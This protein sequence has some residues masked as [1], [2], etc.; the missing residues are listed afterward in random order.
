MKMESNLI[1]DLVNKLGERKCI[2]DSALNSRYVHI[3]KMHEPLMAKCVLLPESTTDVSE[4]MK[5][6]YKYDQKI[7]VHGGLTNLVGSTETNIDDVVISMEKLNDIEEIDVSSRTITAQAGVVLE[8]II[9]TANDNDLLFP[10]NFGAKGS[11]Q[12]GGVISTNAGGL[13]VF[14]YG[15]TR[16]LVLG[17]EVVMANGSIISSM[18]KI[19][20]DNS[21]YDLKQMFIGSEGTLG[22]ITKA[23]LRL[24][25]KPKSRVS[26]LVGLNDYDSVI[27]LLKYMD[28]SLA[29]NLS[30]FE[31]I[32]GKTYELMTSP[33]AINKPPIL[34]GFK[35]YVL[36]EA[37]G[38]HQVNDKVFFESVLAE[39]LDKELFV[40]GAIAQNESDLNWFWNIREDVHIIASQCDH[41]QHFDIS[42]PIPLIGNYVDEVLE[43]LDSCEA[44]QNAYPFGHIADGN[45]HFIVGKDNASVELTNL[46]NDII[47]GPLKAKGG[48]VSAEHG[49]GLHKK[50]YLSLCRSDSEIDLMKQIKKALDP[51]NLLNRNKVLDI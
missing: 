9:N 19:I 12:I 1:I 25:E 14:K 23:V 24:I 3:W 46:V 21:A 37:L 4:I 51:K 50:K 29:G 22:I 36:L 7:V 10:M 35:Y 17:L 34:H 6:C 49:I 42:L 44:V 28:K 40:D 16:N 45:I 11:A 15:M 13:K 31:L 5:I 39:A 43:K 32:W 38:S 20:K 33:P 47:Y 27:G 30:S 2:I 48:S 41:D 26:A 8:N 18:K